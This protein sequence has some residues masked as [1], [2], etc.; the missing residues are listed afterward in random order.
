MTLLAPHITAFLQQRLRIEKG[1]SQH[2]C[3]SYAFAFLLL[4]RFTTEQLKVA[5]SALC[6]EQIDAQLVLAFLRHL[7][8]ARHNRPSS[9][10]VRLAAIK[11]FF[12]FVEHR[13]PS[14]LD[15]IRQ[16][17]AIPSKRTET[18]LIRHLSLKEMLALLETP[19]PT[20]RNGIRDRAMLHLCFTAG[21][22]V[23]ELV[24]VRLDDLS[25]QT[26]PIIQIQ[27]KGRRE[28]A[29]PLC[30]ETT[31]LLRA[32]FAVR[33]ELSVPELFVNARGT[34]M[35]RSGFEYILRKHARKAAQS[36]PSLPG[37]GVSPH[38]L[39][40]TCAMTMLRATGDIRKVA[41]WLGHSSIQTTEIYTQVDPSEKLDAINAITPPVLRRGSFRPPDKLLALIKGD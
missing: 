8:S 26:P 4:F 17:L 41:L 1:A 34:Q 40:H 15:Q 31:K 7:E 10:N 20:T 14:A 38:V 6:L 23:S 11:S 2:T 13:V 9:R 39:R 18:Q 21:L 36:C 3:D 28:R 5:P 37:K 32:W 33:G 27:G 25:L 16:I 30:G 29:L 35:T 19:Q 12:R 24:G 22:R